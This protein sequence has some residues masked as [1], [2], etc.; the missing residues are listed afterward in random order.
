MRR[1]VDGKAFCA[2]VIG[3]APSAAEKHRRRRLTCY[4]NEDTIGRPFILQLQVDFM[5]RLPE[6]Q[7]SKRRQSLF[8]KKIFE[9]ALCLVRRV[10][11]AAS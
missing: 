6:G 10:D 5:R 11:H 4:M 7:F 9:S 1:Y 2:E 8:F 3:D